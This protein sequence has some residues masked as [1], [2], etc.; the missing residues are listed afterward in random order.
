MR[1]ILTFLAF[2][3]ALSPLCA[4][5]ATVEENRYLTRLFNAALA[6]DN[7]VLEK[8]LSSKAKL[9]KVSLEDK[10]LV[11]STLI[12]QRNLKGISIAARTGIDLNQ[13]IVGDREGE[14]V[15]FMPLTQAIYLPGVDST[16]ALH[17]INTGAD[18]NRSS[19]DDEAPLLTAAAYRAH[20][21]VEYLLARG[22]DPNAQEKLIGATPL[23]IVLYKEPD[24]A[25]ALKTARRLVEYGAQ[26]NAITNTGHTTL[27]FAAKSK[28]KAAMEWLLAAGVVANKVSDDGETAEVLLAKKQPEGLAELLETFDR[29]EAA[30][31]SRRLQ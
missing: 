29:L 26:I 28:N 27:M 25:K 16:T 7:R 19:I 4:N 10:S 23:M 11:L 5:A 14:P 8:L 9:K 21:V 22:A 2:T 24:H 30:A 12:E 15:S 3:V 1:A 17:L 20:E 6:S 31:K 13:P 18:V